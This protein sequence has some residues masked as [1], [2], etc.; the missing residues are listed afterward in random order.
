MSQ[1]LRDEAKT[2][3]VESEQEYKDEFSS[4]IFD[5]ENGDQ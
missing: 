3:Q 2:E 1:L 4:S 5:D